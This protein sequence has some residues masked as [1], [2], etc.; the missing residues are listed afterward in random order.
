DRKLF[1]FAPHYVDVD[2]G[3]M[4]YVDEGQ[5]STIVMVHGT[6]DWSFVYRELIG[7]LS[8][9]YRCVAADN[10]GFGLSDKPADWSY[11][12]A[13]HARNF[14]T[15]IDRLE[16]ERFT[17]VVHDFGG[18]IGL[19]YALDHPERVERLVIFNTWMWSLRGETSMR[20]ALDVL[21]GPIGKL[22]YLTFNFSTRVIIP[23]SW[24]KHR[25]LSAEVHRQYV[26]AAPRAPDRYPM[27]CFA[28]EGLA[29]SDWFD[30]LWTRR[31]RIS[32]IPAL[33]IWGMADPAFKPHLI[34]RFE[35]LFKIL[36]VVRY[37]D[38]G[39]FVPDEAGP[40][41]A[42]EIAKFL[43]SPAGSGLP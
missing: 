29:A 9:R 11:R 15:L 37:P 4:H 21:G 43:V 14:A 28:R 36:R 39:H 19:S 2:G 23:M 10:L 34:Q 25:P 3:R 8:D 1:P 26:D 38:V 35:D 27:W 12:M 13:D 33:I 7:R 42:D 18:P 32:Q 41:S 22:L 20:R 31:E 17:L 40:E 16:L 24:G 30:D 5:G 6:P